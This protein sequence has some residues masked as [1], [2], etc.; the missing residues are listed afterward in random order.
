MKS[1]LTI[2]ADDSEKLNLLMRVAQEM[3]LSVTTNNAGDDF[4]MLARSGAALSPEALEK[5]AAE[6]EADDDVLDEHSSQQYLHKLKE[7]WKKA[8]P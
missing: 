6:M 5:L 8:T 3:G 1:T 2:E 4:K 7:V